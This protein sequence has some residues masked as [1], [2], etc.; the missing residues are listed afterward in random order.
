MLIVIRVLIAVGREL[1]VLMATV[2]L[3]QARSQQMQQRL[4]R[5]SLATDPAGT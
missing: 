2:C 4:R 3:Y 5:Q 1:R